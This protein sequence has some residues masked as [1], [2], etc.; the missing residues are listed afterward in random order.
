MVK[1]NLS[2]VVKKKEEI[3]SLCQLAALTTECYASVKVASILLQ[4][5]RYTEIQLLLVRHH[6][7]FLSLFS[8][9]DLQETTSVSNVT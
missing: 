2:K 4:N 8:D 9:S 1:N 5:K 6:L 3:Y 7:L